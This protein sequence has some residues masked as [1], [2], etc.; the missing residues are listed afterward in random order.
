MA[1]KCEAL[2]QLLDPGRLLYNFSSPQHRH[3]IKE[4]SRGIAGGVKLGPCQ[5][6]AKH[7]VRAR[8]KAR[9]EDSMLSLNFIM[10]PI[11]VCRLGEHQTP[12]CTIS[13]T[14]ER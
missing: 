5:L 7:L 2:R 14:K 13:A 3:P 4:F 6:H 12:R 8:D 11:G 9:N 1:R 10:L